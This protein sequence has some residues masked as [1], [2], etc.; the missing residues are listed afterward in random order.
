MPTTANRR[1]LN[2]QNLA[3][4]KTD[5]QT[6]LDEGGGDL[7]TV[8]KMTPTQNI[9]HVA[10]LI[11][12]S[13]N[14]FPPAFRFPPPYRFIGRLL[15]SRTLNNPFPEGIKKMP[16]GPDLEAITFPPA[17]TSLQEATEY[18]YA[19][20]A[21]A[22]APNSMKHPSPL[23]GKLTHD[24]WTRLHCLHADLHFSFLHPACN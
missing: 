8:G 5:I 19:N 6:L 13:V 18:L 1:P 21:L 20:I 2:L 3:E 14:G 10:F 22:S 7:S 15:R 12:S 9:W 24:Q 4:L 11:D 23:F 16:G 17:D